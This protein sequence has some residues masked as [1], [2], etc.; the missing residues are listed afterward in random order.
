MTSN[1]ATE[2]HELLNKLNEQEAEFKLFQEEE[3][4]RYQKYEEMMHQQAKMFQRLVEENRSH[5]A[6]HFQ[7]IRVGFQEVKDTQQNIAKME[8]S[9]IREELASAQMDMLSKLLKIQDMSKNKVHAESKAT[10]LMLQEFKDFVHGGFSQINKNILAVK[11]NVTRLSSQIPVDM[12]HVHHES[13]MSKQTFVQGVPDD[14]VE[15]D[16]NQPMAFLLAVDNLVYQ[17]FCLNFMILPCP[18]IQPVNLN[19][20]LPFLIVGSTMGFCFH[21]LC[22]SFW[23]SEEN[24]VYIERKSGWFSFF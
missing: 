19:V 14:D 9:F 4:K 22:N 8:Q 15:P 10:L 21:C 2:Y 18:R 5:I 24:T 3:K 23:P 16:C 17:F 13:D 20:G 6:E 12:T 11:S 7:N 1:T